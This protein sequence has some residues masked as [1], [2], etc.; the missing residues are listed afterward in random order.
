MTV[1]RTVV[2]ECIGRRGCGCDR[3]RIVVREDQT[4][5]LFELDR[6]S[7]ITPVDPDRSLIE[8]RVTKSDFMIIDGRRVRPWV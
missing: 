7:A 8:Y 6:F 1:T 4:G 3:H 2:G 5:I